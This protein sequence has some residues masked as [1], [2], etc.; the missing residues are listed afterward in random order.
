MNGMNED[1]VC[2]FVKLTAKLP[3]DVRFIEYMPFDGRFSLFHFGALFTLSYCY[4]YVIGSFLSWKRVFVFYCSHKNVC[5]TI[6]V[7]SITLKQVFPTRGTSTPWGYKIKHQR[8]Q[9]NPWTADQLLVN[10]D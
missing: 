8:V 6:I 10:F 4:F 5:K 9:T 1:E 2:E 7:M 3:V